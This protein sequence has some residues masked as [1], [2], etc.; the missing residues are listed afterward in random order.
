MRN[1]KSNGRLELAGEVNGRLVHIVAEYNTVGQELLEEA[2]NQFLRLSYE[3]THPDEY[4]QEQNDA[5]LDKLGTESFKFMNGLRLYALR[6][7]E[8]LL[9]Y[10]CQPRIAQRFLRY[11]SRPIAPASMLALTNQAVILIEEDKAWGASYGWLITLCPR[12]YIVNIESRPN[13]EWRE[14]SV[15]LLGIL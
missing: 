5:M 1:R 2:L 10:V 11:F 13:Q 7:G 12:R 9:G 4:F 14:V 3:S 8:R 6:P 15:R